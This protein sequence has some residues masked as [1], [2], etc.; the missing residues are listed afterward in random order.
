MFP[1]VQ[2]MVQRASRAAR[3]GRVAL[4]AV[5]VVV[6]FSASACL[7][8]PGGLVNGFLPASD[9]ETITPNCQIWVPAAPSLINLLAAAHSQGVQLEPEQCYRTYAEQVTERNYWC[10][11]GLCQFAAV[12]GTS[13]HGWGKAVDFQ[14]QNGSLTF[15]SLGYVW[16]KA[17]GATYCFVHPAWAEPTGSAPEPW[18]WEWVC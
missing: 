5:A 11:L 9:L 14:D 16:L 1:S 7:T 3:R 8:A 4:A 6:A 15:T 10:S 12:P 13:V 2:T 17:N 18:H